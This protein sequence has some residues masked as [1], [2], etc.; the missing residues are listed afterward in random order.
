MAGG[1]LGSEE[2]DIMR[3]EVIRKKLIVE[4]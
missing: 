4:N 3:A 1:P 2:R